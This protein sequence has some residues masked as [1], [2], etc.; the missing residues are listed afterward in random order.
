MPAKILFVIGSMRKTSFNRQLSEAAKKA[1]EGKA[2]V[3]VLEYGDIP[4]MNQDIEFPTP[5]AISRVRKEV[6]AA[7][8]IW[9]FTPE[10]NA[11][12]PGVLKNLLD[13][14][15]RP[16]IANDFASGTAVTG[17][18]FAISGIGG[19]N[20]TAGSRAKLQELLEFMK[21]EVLGTSNGFIVNPEGWQTDALT[22]SAED[23]ERIKQQAEEFLAFIA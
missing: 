18:K 23:Q 8:G 10:Y 20:A 6:Q 4:F 16:L 12:Y 21:V 3:S 11:S 1:L 22:L 15:S 9:I 5:E 14:L 13:W 19:K 7:D 2:E 17:K